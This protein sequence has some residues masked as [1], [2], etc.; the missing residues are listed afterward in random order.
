MLRLT[1]AQM[2]AGVPCLQRAF[3]RRVADALVAKY[4]GVRPIRTEGLVDHVARARA[5]AQALGFG[6]ERHLLDL[7]EAWCLT[8]DRLWSDPDFRR[9][10]ALPLRT[11]EEKA[12]AIRD[13]FVPSLDP[14]PTG[15]DED[16]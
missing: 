11:R 1:K 7:V 10:V 8:G 12:V 4:D 6:A 9:I 13:R 2:D 16:E 15:R 5:R 14:T 3:D